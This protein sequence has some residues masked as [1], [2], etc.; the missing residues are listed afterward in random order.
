MNITTGLADPDITLWLKRARE[1]DED[2][3]GKLFHFYIGRIKSYVRRRLTAQDQA[4]GFDED[5]ANESMT[6]VWQGLAKGKFE[7]VSNREELWFTMM[8]VAKSRAMD[9]RKYLRRKKRMFGI[10]G[11]LA[12]LFER[13]VDSSL[14]ADEF[15]ILEFWEQYIK[16]LPNDE[17]REIVRM[18]LEGKEVNE[19]AT[20]LDSVPKSVQRKLRIVRV[21]WKAYVASQNYS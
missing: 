12:T 20:Q 14:A 3:F 4:E 9:R 21:G 5:L 18:K 7:T 16:T 6:S 13:S 1:G 8:S 15:E 10:T 2:A 11:Q 19:I 17:Y